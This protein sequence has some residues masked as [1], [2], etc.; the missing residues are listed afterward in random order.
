M[1]LR[2]RDSIYINSNYYAI[3]WF[4]FILFVLLCGRH[5]SNSFFLYLSQVSNFSFNKISSLYKEM[6][7]RRQITRAAL[8][9][10][11]WIKL[12]RKIDR[13]TFTPLVS[14]QVK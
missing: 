3:P 7:C 1:Y 12:K 9:I 14:V 4:Y 5:S 2:G 13:E 11:S 10:Y 6:Y 8:S